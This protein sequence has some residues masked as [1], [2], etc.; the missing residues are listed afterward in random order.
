MSSPFGWPLTKSIL[1]PNATLHERRVWRPSRN[2]LLVEQQ[3]KIFSVSVDAWRLS[4]SPEL[5]PWKHAERDVLVYRD[6]APWFMSR[7]RARPLYSVVPYF[8]IHTICCKALAGSLAWN[9]KVSGANHTCVRSSGREAF[10]L[11]GRCVCVLS[12]VVVHR[13]SRK[14]LW[15]GLLKTRMMSTRRQKR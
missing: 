8:T 3:I 14:R 15:A 7:N 13:R 9:A 2:A 5:I 10:N 4:R 1:L 11:C 6:S 12:V